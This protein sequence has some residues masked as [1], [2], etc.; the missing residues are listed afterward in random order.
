M[1]STP[2]VWDITQIKSNSPQKT[3]PGSL[4]REA[5]VL[6]VADVFLCVVTNHRE[7]HNN[8]NIRV[9]VLLCEF[10]D[11]PKSHNVPLKTISPSEFLRKNSQLTHQTLPR[12]TL[13]ASGIRILQLQYVETQFDQRETGKP[14]LSSSTGTKEVSVIHFYSCVLLIVG[15]VQGEVSGF[16]CS[17]LS[18]AMYLN[19]FFI[20]CRQHLWS[21]GWTLFIFSNLSIAIAFTHHI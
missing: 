14:G 16:N 18:S 6:A 10:N 15:R 9:D 21:R 7:S 4:Q 17:L 8:S 11:Q 1:W 13:G 19:S 5:S 20:G 12:F 2:P 3:L